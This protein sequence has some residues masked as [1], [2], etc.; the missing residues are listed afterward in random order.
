M[1]TPFLATIGERV[2]HVHVL[3]GLDRSDLSD[4]AGLAAAHVGMMIRGDVRNP[5]ATTLAELARV[6]GVDLMWL[7][8]GIGTPPT[9]DAVRAAVERA[10]AERAALPTDPA[11]EPAE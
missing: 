3:S 7:A 10:R 4:L 6:T 11:P 9:A 1:A 5:A 8:R 2:A